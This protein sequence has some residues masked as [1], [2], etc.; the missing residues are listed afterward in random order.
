MHKYL[1]FFLL[2]CLAFPFGFTYGQR[3]SGFADYFPL[4]NK[5][6]WEY[7]VEENGENYIQYV[8]VK[9]KESVGSFDIN[10]SGKRA[11]IFKL[12]MTDSIVYLSESKIDWGPVSI[13]VPI[14]YSTPIPV[15]HFNMA[16]DYEW[17]WSGNLGCYFIRKNVNIHF[18]Y[19]G[20]EEVNTIFGLLECVKIKT[21]Y[22]S[23]DQ[24]K[25]LYS[26]FAKGLGLIRER[27][28][29][30]EKKLIYFSQ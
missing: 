13:M 22:N 27:S 28:Y 23:G 10:T 6:R 17:N 1:L 15:F 14:S 4:N 2:V 12:I 30:Y 16:K 5:L 7:S 18:K 25:E 20:I 9:P 21:V 29:N 11:S 26:W 24:S 8:G 19:L 3:E